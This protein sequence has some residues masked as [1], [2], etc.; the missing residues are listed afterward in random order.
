MDG[1]EYA[2][3][4]KRSMDSVFSQW[5]SLYEDARDFI[6]PWLGKLDDSQ[7]YQR[8]DENMVRTMIMKY[9]NVCAAGME[10]SITSPARQWASLVAHDPA[11]MRQTAAREYFEQCSAIL[12]EL[13]LRCRFYP[14]IY[15]YYLE[16]S[17]FGTAAMFVQEDML[18]GVWFHTFTIGE[19]RIGIDSKYEPNAFCRTVYLNSDQY[20]HMFG[21]MPTGDSGM[22]YRKVEHVIAPNPDVDFHAMTNDKFPWKEWYIDGDKVVT[23]GYHEFPL[24][25]GRWLTSGGDFY[26]TGPGIWSLADSKQTQIMWRDISMAAELTINPP[27]QAPSDILANGGVNMLP[28]SANYFNPIGNSDGGIKPIWQVPLDYQGAFQTAKEMETC[29]QEHFNYSVFQ[30]LSSMD[31]GTRTAREVIELSSEKMGM[32]GPILDRMETE[33]LPSIINRVVA[34][35]FRNGI[36]PP[37][38]PEL[39]GMEFKVEYNSILSQAQKQSEITP[40]ID[41]V[42]TGIQI[43]TTSQKPE[44]LDKF[45]FDKAIDFLGERNGIAAG[46]IVDDKEVQQIRYARAQQQQQMMAAQ[47]AAQS[48]EIAKTMSQA[49]LT[50]N[51]A[52]TQVLGGAAG[53]G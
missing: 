18:N 1:R 8:H 6:Y 47:A 40:L 21:G 48:A 49:K 31:K 17:V 24:G 23:S 14:E 28:G 15:K 4:Q 11:V 38:P 41:T 33:V 53:L 29:I 5:K 20:R 39:Q 3:R 37:P 27:I 51:N 52:L 12:R 9:A 46:I 35:C 50:E 25:I 30:L 36:F 44:V 10:S 45:N 13:L 43:A 16:M 26:G 7:S 34:I 42:M 2:L 19:Y 32:M 22:P